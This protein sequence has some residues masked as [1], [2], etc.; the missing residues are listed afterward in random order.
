MAVVKG[1]DIQ[2]IP[3]GHVRARVDPSRCQGHTLRAMIAPETFELDDADGHANAIAGDVPHDRHEAVL[4]AARSCPEQSITV[5][6][7]DG[8]RVEQ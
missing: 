7:A 4:E 5:K 3:G 1:A 8:Q 2:Q 6:G